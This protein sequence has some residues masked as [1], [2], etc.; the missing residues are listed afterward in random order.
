VLHE[1]EARLSRFALEGGDEA[2][3]FRRQE[4]MAAMFPWI[5]GSRQFEASGH[6]VGDVRRARVEG[7]RTLQ[8]GGPVGN[9]GGCDA[10][11][12]TI[13]LVEPPWCVAHVGPGAAV[14]DVAFGTANFLQVGARVKGILRPRGPVEAKRVPFCAGAIIAEEENECPLELARG[15]QV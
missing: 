13:V 15:L 11:F 3:A 5:S 6:D 14:A 9:E 2:D 10:A 1:D 7:T 12:V 8:A 4:R